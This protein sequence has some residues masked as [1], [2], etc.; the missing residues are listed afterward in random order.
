MG[1]KKHVSVLFNMKSVGFSASFYLPF[2]SPDERLIFLCGFLPK[3]AFLFHF[4][5]VGENV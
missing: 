2:P 4:N 5:G 3:D 1:N